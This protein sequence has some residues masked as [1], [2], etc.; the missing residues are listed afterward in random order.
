MNED[1]IRNWIDEQR[2]AIAQQPSL[3]NYGR[4]R[5]LLRTH[6]G[7]AD[8]P[9]IT[10]LL[11]NELAYAEKTQAEELDRMMNETSRRL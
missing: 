7:Y 9:E 4:Y 6:L 3:F 11:K 8:T 1:E 10:A 2:E 5:L